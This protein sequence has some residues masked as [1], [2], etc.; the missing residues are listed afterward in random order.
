M[1]QAGRVRGCQAAPACD[2]D[3]QTSSGARGAPRSQPRKV[4]PSTSSMAMNTCR[5]DGA[6]VVDGHHVR[7]G[8]AGHG[9]RLAQQARA[10]RLGVGAV[11]ATEDSD[12]HP[13]VE[14]GIARGVDHDLSPPAPTVL[15]TS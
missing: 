6:D 10:K 9:L 11:A 15:S 3:A 4:A 1:H 8:Q 7:M 13:A 2:G 5:A 14:L 12:R